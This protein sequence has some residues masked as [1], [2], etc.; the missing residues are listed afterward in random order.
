MRY[1]SL[2][3]KNWRYLTFGSL[4]T[5]LGTLGSGY[6]V[7][8][9]NGA[10]RLEFGLSHAEIGLMFSVT[11]VASGPLL[12]WL[13][14][15]ID[16]VDLRYYSISLCVG[17][18]AGCFLLASSASMI[19]VGVGIFLIRLIG[20]WLIV[21]TAVTSMARHFG[22][23]RG[24]AIGLGAVG[25]A[26]GP[27]VFPVTA[28][29]LMDA[30]GWRATWTGIGGGFLVFI[31]PLILW[32]LRGEGEGHRRFLKPAAN[33]E[34]GGALAGPQ[35]S[36]R[37]VLGDIRFYLV[38]PVAIGLPFI[39]SG[40]FFHQVHMAEAK[41]WSLTWVASCFVG[42]AIGK[43]AS[44]LIAGP[45]I[46]KFGAIRMLPYYPV[47][48]GLGL[49]ALAASDHPGVA[50]AYLVGFG[51]STGMWLVTVGALWAEMY[52]VAHLGAI[53]AMAQAI[54]VL[55]VAAVTVGVGWLLDLGFTFEA[56]ALMSVG[57]LAV[58]MALAALVAR[59]Q[60]H[61]PNRLE[62]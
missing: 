46:D 8:L 55:S 11:T 61:R 47:P 9:F 52:G 37:R 10:I 57:Y 5:C 30:V 36:R 18:G 54:F 26:V 25:Y 50:L 16:E 45:I 60:R 44:A 23:Q 27:A 31:I 21:H 2:F 62:E 35:W 7:G 32:L 56:I 51:L 4:L 49:L 22:A 40:F 14:R 33:V 1:L 15:K 34:R 59:H 58:S 12:I 13:G 41:G 17:F 43:M 20:D 39:V 24:R 3:S 29:L 19:A 48:M 6:F 38:M 28:V 53:R 42:L